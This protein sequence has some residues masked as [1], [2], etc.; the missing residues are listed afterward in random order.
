MTGEGGWRNVDTWLRELNGFMLTVI[1]TE[2]GFHGETRRPDGGLETTIVS[3]SLARAM[4]WCEERART[5][6]PA[7][8]AP[9]PESEFSAEAEALGEQ[10]RVRLQRET[11]TE[12]FWP[13]RD[14]H[15]AGLLINPDT[16]HVIVPAAAWAKLRDERGVRENELADACGE[17]A[18]QRDQARRS[19]RDAL[20]EAARLRRRLENLTAA[21]GRRA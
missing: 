5:Y 17:L 19:E 14:A 12:G 21:R 1:P 6:E 11:W 9:G 13:L 16:N 2:H 7:A 4:E 18:H 3:P 20:A 10:I 8:V 15:Y